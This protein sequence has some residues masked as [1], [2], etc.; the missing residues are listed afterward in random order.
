MSGIYVDCHFCDRL[1]ASPCKFA[2]SWMTACIECQKLKIRI[3]ADAG[4][5]RLSTPPSAQSKPVMSKNTNVHPVSTRS[6]AVVRLHAAT[7]SSACRNPEIKT[8]L[9]LI[10][11][12]VK[13]GKT[14]MPVEA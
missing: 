11:L 4:S 9:P 3:V 2:A 13:L 6:L 14:H 12:T 7:A 5:F 1:L 10:A 8:P